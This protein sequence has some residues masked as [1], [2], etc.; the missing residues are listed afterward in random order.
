MSYAYSMRDAYMANTMGNGPYLEHLDWSK[1]KYISKMFKNG[2]WIYKYA[3]D[4]VDKN[5]TGASAKAR[6]TNFN[7]KAMKSRQEG[8]NMMARRHSDNA[9]RAM[10]QYN[11]SLAGRLNQT[12]RSVKNSSAYKIGK[13]FLSNLS[14]RLNTTISNAR[15]YASAQITKAKDWISGKISSWKRNNYMNTVK[16]NQAA[17]KAA[18]AEQRRNSYLN[19]VKANKTA[20]DNRNQ[21]LSTVKANQAEKSRNQ[22]LSTVK[23]NQSRNNYLNSVKANQAAK[24]EKKLKRRTFRNTTLQKAGKYAYSD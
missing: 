10:D 22:Y 17:K 19:T 11:S 13:S 8:N 23:A 5:I 20:K 7:Q 3:S 12:V 2:K 1:H 15:T 18:K 16:E 24:N 21:Y 6:A 14:D 4:F 9:H